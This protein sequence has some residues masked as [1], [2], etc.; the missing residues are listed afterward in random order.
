M[1]YSNQN[2]LETK[3]ITSKLNLL[4]K[5]KERGT[6]KVGYNS[7]MEP[8]YYFNQ[9]HQ[10]VGFEVTLVYSLAQSLDV[11]ID[12][13]PFKFNDLISG[14]NENQFDIAIGGIFVS[15][16]L[17]LK[18]NVAHPYYQSK[19]AL[20]VRKEQEQQYSSVK[21]IRNLKSL[22]IVVIN[23]PALI[24]IVKHSFPKAKLTIVEKY[25]KLAF[26]KLNNKEFDALVWSE[27]Q[28]RIWS[29]GHP[30]YTYITPDGF[31]QTLL[32]SLVLPENQNH[33]LKYINFW[34]SMQSD[35]GMFKR[36]ILHWI[37]GH[38]H[39]ED[40]YRWNLIDELFSK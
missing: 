24:N 20:I 39:T 28:A 7:Q 32:F 38:P 1:T 37:Y 5:I 2:K 15:N 4:Q 33:L 12:W 6:L 36:E 25:D 17:L 31:N 27:V 35:S 34:L 29:Y 26:K 14:L 9:Y 22:N 3:E 13:V 40:Q 10:L 23:D 21:S 11:G 8:F 30:G 16:E 18:A 19:I